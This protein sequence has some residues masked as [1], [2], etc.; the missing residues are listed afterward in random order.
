MNSPLENQYN[1]VKINK[2]FNKKKGTRSREISL[3]NTNQTDKSEHYETNKKETN[4]I[5]NLNNMMSTRNKLAANLKTNPPIIQK[6]VI[7][8]NK[9][10]K[11]LSIDGGNLKQEK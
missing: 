5:F 10:V 9:R 2:I 4:N 8:F 6:V 7:D 3:N 1:N 11:N